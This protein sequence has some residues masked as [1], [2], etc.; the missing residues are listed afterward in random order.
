[1]DSL[2]KNS[3]VSPALPVIIDCDPGIDDAFALA[4]ALQHPALDVLGVTTVAGNQTI[5]H[6]SRNALDLVEFYGFPEVPVAIGEHGPLRRQ[7]VTANSHGS[8]GLGGRTLPSATAAPVS[9]DAV[10]FMIDRIQEL[11][12]G[13]LTLI[14]IGPLTNLAR[15]IERSPESI[16]RVREVLIMGGGEHAGNM[17][18]VAE[19]NF[20]ADPDAAAIVLAADWPIRLFGLPLTWQSAVPA[21]VAARLAA[22]PGDVAAALSDWLGFYSAG[23]DTPDAD[24]PSLHDAVV[25]AAAIDASLVRTEEVFATV[26]TAGEWTYGENVIDRAGA[27]GK[28]AN[29]QLGVTLDRDRFWTLMLDAVTALSK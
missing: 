10:Q 3:N 12:A 20:Y 7:Q 26:E 6:V 8:D 13:E 11:P 18:P 21:E 15:L 25:V 4:L 24:G 16:S 29:V 5:D 17:T 27:Y 19:F 23:E 22:M 2:R 14:A 1:M 28:A 9:H